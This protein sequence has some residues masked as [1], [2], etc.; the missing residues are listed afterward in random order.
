MRPDDEETAAAGEDAGPT[1]RVVLVR[2]VPGSPLVVPL[3]G[4]TPVDLQ[5]HEPTIDNET[6][7]SLL[8]SSL[9]LIV[10]EDIPVEV[11]GA[12]CEMPVPPLF[13][14]SPWLRRCRALVLEVEGTL[15][16]S[17]RVVYRTG[18]GLRWDSADMTGG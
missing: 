14:T 4:R 17:V 5:A 16:G 3:A 13:R 7:Q 1:V 12:L 6:L 2:P 8:G 15:L 11:V 18:L 10:D 9:L